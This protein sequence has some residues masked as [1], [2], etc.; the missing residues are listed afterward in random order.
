VEEEEHSKRR[1]GCK[2]ILTPIIVLL[3]ARIKNLYFK[4]SLLVIHR[5]G[6]DLQEMTQFQIASGKI[7]ADDTF[8]V[9]S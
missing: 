1:A 7:L 6:S 5:A 8:R 2:S 3:L 9:Q 4:I